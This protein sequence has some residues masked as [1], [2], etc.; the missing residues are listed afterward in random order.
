MINVPLLNGRTL[1]KNRN[2]R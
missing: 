2:W 1:N